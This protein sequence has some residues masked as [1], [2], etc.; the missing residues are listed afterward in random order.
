VSHP[1]AA[2]AFV[3]ERA[4]VEPCRW[5]AAPEPVDQTVPEP[6]TGQTSRQAPTLQV[7]GSR[8]T[9]AGAGTE[10]WAGSRGPPER[11]RPAEAASPGTLTQWCHLPPAVDGQAAG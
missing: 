6:G 3:L 1:A 4:A 7:L 8:R 11:R 5:V 9:A 2:A 10:P